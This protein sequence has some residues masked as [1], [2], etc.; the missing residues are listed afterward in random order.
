[1]LKFVALQQGDPKASGI[2][3]SRK[4]SF[5]LK[6][7]GKRC[8]DEVAETANFISLKPEPCKHTNDETS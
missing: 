8:Y 5:A 3:I 4:G 1:M 7:T 2:Q 6:D